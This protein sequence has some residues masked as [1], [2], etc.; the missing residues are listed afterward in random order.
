MK[1][2][3]E[4]GMKKL[5]RIE[6]QYEDGTVDCIEDPRAALLFQSRCNS[7]GVLSGLE[8]NIITQ[9]NKKS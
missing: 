1:F 7:S 3:G 5:K 2:P 8:D 9:E 6:F 4:F